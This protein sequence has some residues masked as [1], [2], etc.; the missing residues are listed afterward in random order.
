MPIGQIAKGHPS[1][2]NAIRHSSSESVTRVEE[3]WEAGSV[4]RVEEPWEAGS[5]TRVEEPSLVKG[6]VRRWRDLSLA[7]AVT[8][9]RS[10]MR[11]SQ[12]PRAPAAHRTGHIAIARQ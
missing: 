4:T 7:G 3:P 12:S 1:L 6:S 8:S 9:A 11:R 2:I 10:E 5:I